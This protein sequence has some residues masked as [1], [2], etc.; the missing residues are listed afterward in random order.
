MSGTSTGTVTTFTPTAS[1]PFAFDAMLDGQ[2][3]S[4]AVTWN[5]WAQ[6]WYLNVYDTSAN[7]IVCRALIAS[8]SPPAVPINLLFG[9]FFT[10]IMVFDDASQSFIVTP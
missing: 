7:L 4:C 6:R 5:L 3:Y 1:G 8:P 2:N 10:S 9:Y